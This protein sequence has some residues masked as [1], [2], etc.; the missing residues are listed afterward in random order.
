M[1]MAYWEWINNNLPQIHVAI[2]IVCLVTYSARI[3][4]QL[5]L[6]RAEPERKYG[7]LT[8]GDIFIYFAVS[9]IPIV[10]AF[11]LLFDVMKDIIKTIGKIFDAPVIKSR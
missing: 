11:A 7:R 10:N 8:Y 9:V 1:L 2:M 4:K 6:D 3:V 5:L